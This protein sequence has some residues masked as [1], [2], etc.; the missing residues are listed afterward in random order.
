MLRC[1]KDSDQ[2]RGLREM[3]LFL[4]LAFLFC[5]GSF[6]GWV[7]EVIFRRLDHGKWINPGFLTGPALPLYGTGLMLMY[8][9]CRLCE[10]VQTGMPWLDAILTL[11]LITAV[12]TLLEYLTGIVLLKLLNLR[13]WDYTDNFGN[14]QG[15]I[16][17]LYT[18]CWG[19]LA[20]AYRFLLHRYAVLLTGWFVAHPACF[21]FLGIFYGVLLVDLAC[22]LQLAA[23]LRRWTANSGIIVK[24]EKL[25]ELVYDRAKQ[26]KERVSF[27]FALHR[28]RRLR[29]TVDAYLK[30]LRADGKRA[31]RIFRRRKK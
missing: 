19:L 16:C 4:S 22:S 3:Q 12:M 14:L 28:P 24:Y 30:A 13:L 31:T 15:I 18:A 1:R 25:K 17:P 2:K 21:F 20:V 9:I 6:F 23:K 7:L 29:E 26:R 27:F 8:L 5:F 11:L 10:G